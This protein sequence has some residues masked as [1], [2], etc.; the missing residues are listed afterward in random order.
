MKH[1]IEMEHFV[2]RQN[3][4]RYKHLLKLETDPA[5]RPKRPMLL[6]LLAE[7]EAKQATTA[8]PKCPK[9]QELMAAGWQVVPRVLDH[10]EIRKFRCSAC[11]DVLTEVEPTGRLPLPDAQQRAL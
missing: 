5:K 2:E 3:V 11:G 1:F 6:K 10:P 9:C 4:E 7:E 8:P